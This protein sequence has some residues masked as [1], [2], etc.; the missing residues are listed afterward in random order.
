MLSF[1]RMLRGTFHMMLFRLNWSSHATVIAPTRPSCRPA[2]WAVRRPP[3]KKNA[4][5]VIASPC[6]RARDRFHPHVPRPLEGP[7][8]LVERLHGGVEALRVR[9]VPDH[10]DHGD[11]LVEALE[12]RPAV[13]V[14]PGAVALPDPGPRAAP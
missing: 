9:R 4:I 7:D 13:L 8:R 14:Q 3:P 5:G 11:R 6:R 2:V 12:H 1:I 10:R